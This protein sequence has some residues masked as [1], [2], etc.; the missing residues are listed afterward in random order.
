MRV[1]GAAVFAEFSPLL[2]VVLLTT[3]VVWMG[4]G[5]GEGEAE[6]FARTAGQWI[7]P[8]GG[9]LAT[10]LAAWWASANSTRPLRVAAWV[11]GLV[12]AFGGVV[13]WGSQSAI[14]WIHVVSYVGKML[15]A[16]LGGAAKAKR[17]DAVHTSGTHLEGSHP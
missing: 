16:L 15:A 11:G 7:G 14:E 9:A 12:V 3:G 17:N 6:A 4:S 1:L 8:I 13:L 10:F 2:V 5:V